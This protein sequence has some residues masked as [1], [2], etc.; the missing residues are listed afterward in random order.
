MKFQHFNRE[1]AQRSRDLTLK[2]SI[3]Q[4]CREAVASDVRDIDEQKIKCNSR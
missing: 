3:I 1:V 2:S 4:V